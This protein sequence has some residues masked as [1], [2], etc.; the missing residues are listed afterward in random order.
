MVTQGWGALLGWSGV[1]IGADSKKESLM[2]KKVFFGPL[3]ILFAALVVA[4]FLQVGV[5][6]A[7]NAAQSIKMKG[8]GLKLVLSGPITAARGT[9]LKLSVDIT[10]DLGPTWSC[11]NGNCGPVQSVIT[12]AS[13]Q[14]LVVD[15]WT[16]SVIVGPVTVPVN[17]QLHGPTVDQDTWQEIP[18]DTY[19]TS[20]SLSIPKNA[21][22]NKAFAVLIYAVDNAKPA[23]VVRG[24]AGW[25]F[26]SQ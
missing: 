26:T 6:T 2:K 8:S 4:M 7:L 17:Q 20:V 21:A 5:P 1:F 11:N 24:T 23:A 25:G 16:G 3:F 10:N 12:C 22:A 9:A 19:T 18:G 13:L 14:A 15:P